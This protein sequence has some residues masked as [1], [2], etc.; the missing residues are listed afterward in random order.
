MDAKIPGKV[1]VKFETNILSK[2]TVGYNLFVNIF[3]ILNI[4]KE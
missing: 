4:P 1:C 3:N 2:L